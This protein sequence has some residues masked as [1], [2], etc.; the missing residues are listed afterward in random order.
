MQRVLVIDH[1]EQPLMPCEPARARELLRKGKAAVFRR[2]PFTI[3]LTAREGGETQPVAL[4][5]DPG[6]KVSGIVLVADTKRGKRVMWAAEVEH[7]GTQ[8]K[9]ALDSRRASRRSRRQRHTRYRAARF[10]NRQRCEGWL[11]SSLQ[12][13]IEQVWTWVQRLR[14]A[15]PITSIAQEL[16]KFDTHLLQNA[17][18]SGVAYQQ[19]TLA[20]YEIREYLLEKWQRRCAYCG[21]PD[22]P[23][24]IE[25]IVPKSRQGTDRVSNLTLACHAC[26]QRKGNQTATEFGYPHLQAHATLPLKDAAVVNTTR[27]MLCRRLQ[28]TRLPVE[29]GTGGQTK[30]NRVLQGY[31]KAHWI[32]AA[33]VGESGRQVDLKPT[34]PYLCIKA[35]GHGSRQLCRT[36]KYGVPSRHRLRQKQ[37]F[38]FQ[39]GDLVHAHV[40]IG[41]YAGKHVGRVACRA[42]GR[43]DINTVNGKVTVSCKFIRVIHHNDGYTYQKGQGAFPPPRFS[44]GYPAPN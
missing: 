34:Q 41:K 44:E 11:P 10:A 3:V 42:T 12:S 14:R 33:C 4:K 24:E 18:I 15:C 25:H 29:V 28:T 26:N 20:G 43:F 19:G 36:D 31:A 39:T 21:K 37:H 13:R 35:T 40:P 22:V 2:F 32:D 1:Q 8:I 5:V 30:F 23:L 27:W 17:E 38:T 6:S 16:V 9:M 7:R